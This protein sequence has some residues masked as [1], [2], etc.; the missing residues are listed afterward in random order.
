MKQNTLLTGI[1][2]LSIVSLLLTPAVASGE[3]DPLIGDWLLKSDFNGRP[4]NS[5]L[6][7]SKD[8]AGKYQ[9]S[10]V[11]FWGI[12]PVDNLKIEDGKVGFTQ[13][14]RF[15][16]QETTLTFIGVLKDGTLSGIMTG[17][18]WENEFEGSLIAPLPPVVGVWEFRRQRQ[19]TEYVS[20]LTVSPDKD[21]KL[22][23]D[24]QSQR[25]TWDIADV[26]YEDDKL[27]FTRKST[28]PERQWE[29]TYALTAKDDTIT[30]TTTSSRG[31]RET[32]GKRLH[33]DLIGKWELTITSDRGDRKQLLWIRPDMTALYGSTEV[34]KIA[35][36][37]D[38]ISFSYEMSFGDRSFENAFK[39]RLQAGTLTGEMTNSRGTQQVK[40]QKMASEGKMTTTEP[41]E[42]P[43]EKTQTAP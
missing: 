26:K 9:G 42:K 24:W 36:E 34:G 23:A 41:E 15:R 28:N 20:T 16:D 10:W 39:G 40:G 3:K 30:G 37:N 18:Q 6:M 19:D 4:V 27:T 31:Q 22:T 7:V 13:T 2:I 43:E 35:V 8:G 21:G 11:S 29:T 25:G 33:G 12:N 17:G 5:L 38:T 32:E 14:N 1:V